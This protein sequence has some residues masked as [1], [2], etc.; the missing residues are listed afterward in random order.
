V[1]GLF[2]GGVGAKE[3]AAARRLEQP[4]LAV[5]R[6]E[7]AGRWTA[8]EDDALRAAWAKG[9][10]GVGA[11]MAA[12]GRTWEACY[13]R[14]RRLDLPPLPLEVVPIAVAAKRAG[15]GHGRARAAIRALGLPLVRRG[16]RDQPAASR[17]W[18]LPPVAAEALVRA[19][20]V[21]PRKI[22]DV[23]RGKRHS[24]QGVWGLGRKPDGC[25]LCGTRERPHY[26][27]GYCQR[28]YTTL[29]AAGRQPPPLRR[30]ETPGVLAPGVGRALLA[31]VVYRLGRARS[32]VSVPRA[33]ERVGA[34]KAETRAAI[35]GLCAVGLAR[36]VRDRWSR[37][38]GYVLVSNKKG[39]RHVCV[40]TAGLLRAARGHGAQAARLLRVLAPHWQRRSVRGRQRPVGRLNRPLPLVPFLRCPSHA[41]RGAHRVLRGLRGAS[42]RSF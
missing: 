5:P 41:R 28:H 9:G 24:P 40:R 1:S 14:S 37:P 32:P 30:T 2:G 19:L 34:S 11:A 12:T 38:C 13:G 35:E 29:Q 8:D 39:K 3:L 21:A 36:V 33:A 10:G 26:C 4:L 6:A 7:R 22:A 16:A 27:G 17:C 20:A 42:E 23:R 31:A 25:L 18:G 15:V